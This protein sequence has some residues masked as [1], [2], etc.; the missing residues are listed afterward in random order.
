MHS[1]TDYL[2]LPWPRRVVRWLT[3]LLGM[4]LIAAGL[5]LAAFPMLLLLMIVILEPLS[6]WRHLE[7]VVFVFAAGAIVCLLVGLRLKRGRRGLVL[8]LRRFGFLSA[9]KTL[10]FA[11][12]TGI[13]RRHRLVTLADAAIVAQGTPVATRRF[14][15]GLRW[16]AVPAALLGL[17]FAVHFVYGGSMDGIMRDVA[18][19][20]Q[21]SGQSFG[22][23]IAGVFIGAFVGAI[24]AVMLVV[25]ILI[26]V[27]VVAMTGLAASRAANAVSKAEKAQRFTLSKADEVD[28]GIVKVVRLARKVLAPRL[29]VVG[30]AD[31]VWQQVVSRLATECQIAIIDVSE[32]T[33]HVVWEV[34]TTAALKARAVF[35]GQ[36]NN[37][38]MLAEAT[39]H[40]GK[41]ANR[42]RELLAD[43]D[44]LVYDDRD[45]A[46][47]RRFAKALGVR[48][49]RIGAGLV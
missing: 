9:S 29:V 22:E 14:V 20:A 43:A 37:V 13:G 34:E 6:G 26:Q 35:V 30:C 39:P 49:D 21:G 31:A 7:P 40:A 2:P 16:I 32:P 28:A 45:A 4:L 11:V 12:G 41:A 36:R 1:V 44:V 8:F 3:G 5:G 17:A 25:L 42:L 23:Q 24:V 15:R 10:S 33:D 18:S 47:P 48:L 19:S 27:T 38:A 46:S